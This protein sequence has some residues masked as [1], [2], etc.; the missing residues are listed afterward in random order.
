MAIKEFFKNAFKDMKESAQA[1]K[2]VSKA[3]M[4]AVKAESR[5]QFKE[6][7]AMGDPNRRKAVMQAERDKQILVAKERTAVAQARMDAVNG[8]K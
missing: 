6:A 2:E 1:Q 5:A 7:K 8:K 4:E 3:E